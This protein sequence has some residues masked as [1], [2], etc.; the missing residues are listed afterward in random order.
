MRRLAPALLSLGLAL[1]PLAPLAAQEASIA[2]PSQATPLQQRTAQVVE[3]LNGTLAP[4]EAMA[5]SFLQSV[6]AEQIKAIGAQLTSQFGPALAVEKIEPVSPARAAI[7]IRME[8]AL[9]SGGIAVQTEP[10]GK[11]T[12]LLLQNFEPIDDSAAKI[13]ADLAALPGSAAAWFG[14]IEGEP[15][16][17]FGDPQQPYALGSTFKL[18]VLS[19]LARAVEEGRL[20]WDDVV[21][22]GDKSFP[23]GMLQ[24][25]P[26]GAPLTLHTA[27]TLMISISDNTATDL[28][29]DAIGREAVEAEMRATGHSAPEL[30]TPFLKTVEFFVLKGGDQGE[31]YARADEAA[32]RAMLEQL[33]TQGVDPAPILDLFSGG[34][35]RLIDSVEWFAS[36]AD[37]RL[38]MRRLVALEDDTARKIMAVNTALGE[39]AREGWEY[40]GYKGGSEPG[41]RNL[42]WLLRDE[43]GQ[44]HMLALGWND[45]QSATDT[46]TLLAIAQR[47]LALDR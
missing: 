22:L 7:T 35:P 16:F 46:T 14:P 31:A 10:P 23:S 11:I 40:V 39:S 42:S 18:Y 37:E 33:V 30:S 41:V 2:E 44:W 43:A 20:G 15:E 28:L 21:T 9:A 19:A 4:E 45:P 8:R 26:E 29:I 25:W 1:A 47:I 6:S 17:V 5:A 38:L 27:A 24:D 36:M 34:A 32:R 3:L 13:A 12:E